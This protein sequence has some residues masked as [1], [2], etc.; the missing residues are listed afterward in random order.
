MTPGQHP[1]TVG[2][3]AAGNPETDPAGAPR[4]PAPTVVA[5]RALAASPEVWA[6]VTAAQR[7]D[8]EAFGQLYARYA[9]KVSRFVG[10]RVRGDRQ[11]TQDLTSE[12]FLRALRGIGSVS[13][14]GR[15]PGAWFTTIARN[16]VLDHV[17]SSRYRLDKPTADVGAAAAGQDGPEQTSIRNE[18][19]AELRRCVAALPR[20][21]QECIRL[22]FMHELSVAETAA[23]MGRSDSAVKGLTHRGVQQLRAALADDSSKPVPSARE[24]AVDPLDAG[25][26]GPP[27]HRPNPLARAQRAVSEVARCVAGDGH[28]E[29]AEQGR[30]QQLARWRADDQGSARIADARAPTRSAAGGAA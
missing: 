8:R 4:S 25:P 5:P 24:T 16:L 13:D 29:A 15:D 6:L 21:Q 19:V 10:S 14:R 17:K 11:L 3:S 20:D 28:R 27:R 22:R 2:S 1:T 18:T 23:V 26:V 12:T 30:A 9:G 7:G